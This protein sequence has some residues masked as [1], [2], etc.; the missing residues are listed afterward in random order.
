MNVNND[1]CCSDK[2]IW[3]GNMKIIPE[4]KQGGVFEEIVRE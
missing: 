3:Q 4:G 2:R 1:A